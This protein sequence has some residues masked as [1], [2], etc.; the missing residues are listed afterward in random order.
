[1]L[2]P[3]VIAVYFVIYIGAILGF[4]VYENKVIYFKIFINNRNDKDFLLMNKL[5]KI[6]NQFVNLLK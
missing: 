4:F 5:K 6:V 1:M 2:G 3:S